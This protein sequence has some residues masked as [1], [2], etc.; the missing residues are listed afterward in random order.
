VS[1]SAIGSAAY[2]FLQTFF[3]YFLMAVTECDAGR[4][5]DSLRTKIRS[6]TDVFG[7]FRNQPSLHF[8]RRFCVSTKD[9]QSVL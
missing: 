4:Q 8:C 1:S 2:T 6:G 3:A 5:A 9:M 7:V